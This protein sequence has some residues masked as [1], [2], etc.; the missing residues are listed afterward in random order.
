MGNTGVSDGKGGGGGSGAGVPDIRMMTSI[1]R[2]DAN[3]QKSDDLKRGRTASNSL[4]F[5]L[6]P[7]S[8]ILKLFT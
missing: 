3:R 8:A 2:Q 4:N 1:S 7:F 5:L 6:M